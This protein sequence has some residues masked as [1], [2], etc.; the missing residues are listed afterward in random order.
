[1][2]K[3]L[4]FAKVQDQEDKLG[5]FR[6]KFHIPSH[7]DGVDQT[8]FCGHSLG[9]QPKSVESAVSEA[10]HAWKTLGVRGHFEGELPW[11]EYND[12]LRPLLAKL[13]GAKAPEIVVMNT[14]TVNLHLLMVSFFRPQGKRRKI[15]IEKHAFPS[16]R[17][18][19]VSQLRFHGLDPTDCL[20]EL[21]PEAGSQLIKESALENCLQEH[22]NEIALVLWPGVQYISGQA[23]DLARVTAAAHRAGA[24][25]GFDLAHYI[26]NLPLSL[27]E[28]GC[29]FAAWCHYKYL[30]AGP[31]AVA[32]CFIHERHHENID[33]PRFHGWWGN[34]RESLFRMEPDFAPATGAGAWQ[35]SNPPILAMA[36]LRASLEIFDQAGMGALRGKSRALAAFLEDGIRTHLDQQIE[37]LTPSDPARR[38]CQLSMRVRSGRQN[39]WQLYRFLEERGVITDWREP[40]VIRVAPVPLYNRFE[41]CFQLLRQISDWSE[42]T[43]NPGYRTA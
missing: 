31:G 28:C 16:D 33:L 41:D 8:Y 4:Q 12:A 15:L 13:A 18:A 23:F 26:G 34:D 3:L 22:G 27:H 42:T 11:I 21:E 37:I 17:Y 9:L 39:G 29:D 43:G 2:K 1:M 40:D 19:V 32:A 6:S 36:P 14:L 5:G 30:N 38:G 20:L 7:R 24:Q 35:L 25:V 10:L